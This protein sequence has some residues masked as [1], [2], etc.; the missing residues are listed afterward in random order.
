MAEMIMNARRM[1]AEPSW[2]RLAAFI[3]ITVLVVAA[4]IRIAEA[5]PASQAVRAALAATLFT[6][7]ATGAGALP[8]LVI[9]HISAPVRDTLLGFGAGVMLAASFF[10]LLAPALETGT[11]VAGSPI[12]GVLIVSAGV[13]IGAAALMAGDRWMP[14]EHFIKGREVGQNVAAD[15]AAGLWLF[16]TAITLHNLPEGLAVGVAQGSSSGTAITLGI[17]IQN[18]PE[19]LIVAIALVTL[20]ISRWKAVALAL[21][22]GMAEPLGG[23][24]GASAI[25]HAAAMLPWGLAFAAGAM[26]FVISHE[27]IPETHRHGNERVATIGLIGGFVLMMLF[28]TILR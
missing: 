18:M 27:I 5:I 13:I 19:G 12:G 21:A 23:L 16:V 1:V 25:S 10:S 4:G 9:R 28:D 11:A 2:Q 20:G 14:H 7:L 6:A 3:V 17:A 24:I 8:V 15:N 22:T 26:L